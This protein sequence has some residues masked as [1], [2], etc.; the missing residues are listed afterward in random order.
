VAICSSESLGEYT[1]MRFSD[2]PKIMEYFPL[3]LFSKGIT[4]RI[5][6]RTDSHHAV[7]C[8]PLGCNPS[9]ENAKA[10]LSTDDSV[11]ICDS[12]GAP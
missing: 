7:P 11:Q 5:T 9:N 2:L 1:L 6:L 4:I 3:M 10:D 8:F 12:G